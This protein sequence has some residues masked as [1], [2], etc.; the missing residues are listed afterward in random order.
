MVVRHSGRNPDHLGSSPG[1]VRLHSADSAAA[2]DFRRRAFCCPL[3]DLKRGRRRTLVP[4]QSLDLTLFWSPRGRPTQDYT[5]FLHLLDSLRTDP[6]SGRFYL[7]SFHWVPAS[8]TGQVSHLRLGRRRIPIAVLKT[9][10][11]FPDLPP[12]LPA[13][14]YTF[15]IGLYDPHHWSATTADILWT[16]G[17]DGQADQDTIYLVISGLRVGSRRP[18]DEVGNEPSTLPSSFQVPRTISNSLNPCRVNGTGPAGNATIRAID[19][20]TY[21][22]IPVTVL[23]YSPPFGLYDDRPWSERNLPVV[24]LLVANLCSL[25]YTA[26]H[27][28]S[29]AHAGRKPGTGSMH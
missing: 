22:P 4:G 8:R 23:A 26:G 3:G 6:K 15:A 29:R 24:V 17:G 13:G 20:S 25:E 10:T 9:C 11:P 5:V 2:D 19:H 27:D 1:A 28:T 14:D 12:D 18:S 7:S 21:S 16:R